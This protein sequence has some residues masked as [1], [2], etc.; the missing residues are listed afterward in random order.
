MNKQKTRKVLTI[1][2]N[3]LH[4]ECIKYSDDAISYRLYKVW[5]DGGW[6]RREIVRF[7]AFSSVLTYIATHQLNC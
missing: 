4:V 2:E 6:H 1:N 5:W 7:R 3:G